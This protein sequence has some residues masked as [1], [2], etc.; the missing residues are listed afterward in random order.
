MFEKLL[1][2]VPYNPGLVPQLAF[3]SRRMREEASIRRTGTIFLVLAFMLQFFAVFSPPQS[4]FAS[5]NPNNNILRDGISSRA[6]AVSKC[7]NN[8]QDFEHILRRFGITCDDIGR[9]NNTTLN[10]GNRDY[11]SMGRIPNHDSSE[12]KIDIPG[13]NVSVYVHTL[14]SNALSSSFDALQLHASNN[15]G[16]IFFLL[17][18]CGNIASV[19]RPPQITKTTVSGPITGTSPAPTPTTP[20][21]T[22]TPSNPTPPPPPPTTPP[23]PPTAPKCKYSPTL[24]ESDVNCKACDKSTSSSDTSA[25]VTISK[26][27]I[28]AATGADANNTTAQPGNV[29]TYTLKVANTAK[30]TVPNFVFQENISDVLEYADLI[31]LNGGAIDTYKNVSWPMQDIAAGSTAT[32]QITVKVKDPIPNTPLDPNNPS[33]FDL[34][35]TNTYGNTINIK[36]PASPTKQAEVAAAALP[37][38]GPGETL[39]LGAVVVILAGYFY[40]RA[41]LLARES[42]IAVKETAY[43]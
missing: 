18:D 23:P 2:L 42:D 34:Y 28:N 26:S 14:A 41:S 32:H 20:S 5:S 7:R 8:T 38:T 12:Y 27:A 6:D 3:Y 33:S 30:E 13:D 40:S 36:V 11:W 31:S 25:C 16:H 39:M 29:I 21:F 19:G 4:T 24:D 17:K 37:N 10:V 9:A 35:M 1:S 43:V 15:D 22:P